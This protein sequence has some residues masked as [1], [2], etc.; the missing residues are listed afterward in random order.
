MGHLYHLFAQDTD[1]NSGLTVIDSAP[2]WMRRAQ[3]LERDQHIDGQA[4]HAEGVSSA[5]E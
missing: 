2:A 5:D 1:A 4:V 3:L